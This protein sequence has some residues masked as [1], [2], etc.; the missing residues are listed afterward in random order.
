MDSTCVVCGDAGV[1]IAGRQ[2]DERGEGE[3]RGSIR[4][5]EKELRAQAHRAEAGLIELP[6]MEEPVDESDAIA[7][8]ADDAIPRKHRADLPAVGEADADG[9]AQAIQVVAEVLILARRGRREI[10]SLA[11]GEVLREGEDVRVHQAAR[12]SF[13][14][15]EQLGDAARARLRPDQLQDGRAQLIAQRLDQSGRVI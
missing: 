9:G 3:A 10:T 8:I 15:F 2:I 4:G 1:V 14:V 6:F 5:G 12:R 7:A 11:R 13:V